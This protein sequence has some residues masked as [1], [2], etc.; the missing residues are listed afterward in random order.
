[1]NETKKKNEKTRAEVV[2]FRPWRKAKRCGIALLSKLKTRQ[3]LFTNSYI[4]RRAA[5]DIRV[6]S[7]APSPLS[8]NT[9]KL[10]Y[11]ELRRMK[12]LKKLIMFVRLP[13]APRRIYQ[14]Q[15]PVCIDLARRGL[16]SYNAATFFLRLSLLHRDNNVHTRLRQTLHR[17]RPI[18]FA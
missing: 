17:R 13:R 18:Q 12:T 4:S 7:S 16:C 10:C 5:V 15:F 9:I 2:L 8:S 3:P 14:I 1:M 6:H 11:A